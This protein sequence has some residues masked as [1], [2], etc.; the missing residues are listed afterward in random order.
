[1]RLGQ[2]Y[3]Q[4]MQHDELAILINESVDRDGK[5]IPQ[6]IHLTVMQDIWVASTLRHK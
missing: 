1:M 3:D 5:V 2:L 6:N 4:A